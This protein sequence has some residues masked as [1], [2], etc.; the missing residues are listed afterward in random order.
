MVRVRIAN[1]TY[2]G[3]FGRIVLAKQQ[4][5]K[6]AETLPSALRPVAI[7]LLDGHILR[8][9]AAGS[10]SREQQA[11]AQKLRE[12]AESAYRRAASGGSSVPGGTALSAQAYRAMGFLYRD[13][14][15]SRDCDAKAAFGKYLDLQP[16]AVDADN[17]RQGVQELRC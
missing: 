15:P 7:P 5:K 10:Q 1:A 16:S 3:Y 4:M 6:A 13:W 17:V 2:D 11:T 12:A 8:S 14:A 9:A